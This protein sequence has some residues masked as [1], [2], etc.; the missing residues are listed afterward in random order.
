MNSAT[1]D[2]REVLFKSPEEIKELEFQ[3]LGRSNKVSLKDSE[4]KRMSNK[5]MANIVEET[6]TITDEIKMKVTTKL[7]F[8]NNI[9]REAE[10][11]KR[12]HINKAYL[13]SKA[14]KKKEQDELKRE[15]IDLKFLKNKF[16]AAKY[17]TLLFQK[18]DV[19]LPNETHSDETE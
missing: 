10:L 15:E 8:T 2:V 12:L 18:E 19:N 9:A 4:M 3:M 5:I 16:S 14:T 13:E 6:V 7:K 1:K 17:L 11:D